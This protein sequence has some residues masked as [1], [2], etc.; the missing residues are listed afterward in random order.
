MLMRGVLCTVNVEIFAG[1]YFRDLVGQTFRVGVNFAVSG[2][3]NYKFR[4]VTISRKYCKE[5]KVINV[6]HYVTKFVSD[7]R[8]VVGFL[9]TLKFPPPIKMTSTI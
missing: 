6:Q 8:Q 7:L 3:Q 9:W 4:D 2:L 5:N 1:C